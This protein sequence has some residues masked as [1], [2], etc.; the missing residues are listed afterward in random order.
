MVL[1][2]IPTS[3]AANVHFAPRKGGRINQIQTH[4]ISQIDLKNI[5][6][7]YLHLC[8]LLLFGHFSFFL[9]NLPTHDLCSVTFENICKLSVWRSYSFKNTNT[10]RQLVFY[11]S[12]LVYYL[13]YFVIIFVYPWASLFCLKNDSIFLKKNL[14]LNVFLKF[15]L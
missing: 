14:C 11:F 9:D 13:F 2:F 4:T 12:K 15:Y 8:L 3:S 1:A 5:F 10:S 6:L 7:I